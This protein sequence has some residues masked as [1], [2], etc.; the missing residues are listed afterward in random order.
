MTKIKQNLVLFMEENENP[1]ITSVKAGNMC[2]NRFCIEEDAAFELSEVHHLKKTLYGIFNS[3]GLK[4]DKG[5][6]NY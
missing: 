6:K 5:K 3:N 2:L 1:W 4:E